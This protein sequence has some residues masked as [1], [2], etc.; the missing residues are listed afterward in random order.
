MEMQCEYHGEDLWEQ[1]AVQD[2][3]EDDVQLLEGDVIVGTEDGMSSIR[4]SNRVHQILYK[5]MSRTIVMKLLGRKVG[6]HALSNKIY[7]LWKPSNPITIMDLKSDYYLVKLQEEVDYVRALTE[8]PWIANHEGVEEYGLWMIVDQWLRRADWSKGSSKENKKSANLQGSQCNAPQELRENDLGDVRILKLEIIAKSKGKGLA[9][10]DNPL[11]VG[12]S[13]L[14]HDDVKGVGLYGLVNASEIINRKVRF[15]GGWSKGFSGFIVSFEINKGL[16]QIG[17][18][19]ILSVNLGANAQ[20][21]DKETSMQDKSFRK[22]ELTTIEGSSSL[23]EKVIKTMLNVDN[24][25]VVAFVENQNPN[26]PVDVTMVS[27]HLAMPL[28]LDSRK[29]VQV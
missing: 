17:N 11:G 5:N 24:H 25:S 1:L 19:L 29:L 27:D 9:I 4:F 6:Y 18:D 22:I 2:K 12:E 8:G 15:I 10:Y 23:V 26:L 14:D 16:S 20:L 7:S 21:A 28:G 13:I 3:D